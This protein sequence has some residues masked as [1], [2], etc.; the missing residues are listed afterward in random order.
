M[1]LHKQNQQHKNLFDTASVQGERKKKIK[2]RRNVNGT[3]KREVCM[4]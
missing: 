2:E 3:V 1:Y 4:H